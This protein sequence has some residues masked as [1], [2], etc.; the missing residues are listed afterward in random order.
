MASLKRL[1]HLD[2]ATSDLSDAAS[3]YEKNFGFK[4]TRSADGNSASIKIG[5]SEIRLASGDSVADTIAKAGEGM[6]GLW[7]EADDVEAVAS[8]LTKSGI[9][10]GPVQKDQNR[11]VLKRPASSAAVVQRVSWALM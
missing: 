5:D 4:V 3:V 10:A 8:A 6:F 1:D 2:V 11:R 7:L 9:S